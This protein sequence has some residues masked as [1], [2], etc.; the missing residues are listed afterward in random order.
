MEN[1][2]TQ[3][4]AEVL[5]KVIGN[6]RLAEILGKTMPIKTNEEIIKELD[7]EDKLKEVYEKI[8]EVLKKYCDLK[9]EYYSLIALWIIGTHCHKQFTTF[10]YLFFNAMKGSGKSRLLKLIVKLAKNGRLVN[11]MSEAVLFRTAH[12]RTFGI[13]E[14]ENVGGKEKQALRELLNSAYKKG[15]A[16]ERAV[17]IK[18]KDEEDYR[19]DTYDLYCPIVMANIWGMDEVLSDRCISITIDKSANKRITRLIEDYDNDTAI[20][21]INSVVVSLLLRKVDAQAWNEYITTLNNTT[22]NNDTTIPLTTL[23]DT[24]RHYID[25]F[26]KIDHSGID[27]RHL[28]LFFPI[29]SIA[30]SINGEI[31]DKT[32]ETAKNI[33]K[34]KKDEDITESKDIMFLEFIS[35]SE[36]T[37]GSIDEFVTE[38]EILDKYRQWAEYDERNEEWKWLNGKWIG[39]ALKRLNLIIE[40]K[41]F[42]KG[43]MVKLDFEFAK[44][45]ARMFKTE[46]IKTEK[47]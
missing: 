2:I 38:K 45:K 4:E 35:H 46:D 30:G 26:E 11:S 23:N 34:A 13:D 15:S 39:R 19:I 8:I 41:R 36:H 25:L 18:G 29:F 9:E 10:P 7:Q 37:F 6:D 42:A 27:S 21:Y 20:L 5:T 1:G 16:V 24:K 28:E 3:R 32:I 47:I 14:F 40:K 44:E 33:S 31:L 43:R 22:I 12:M 17:K